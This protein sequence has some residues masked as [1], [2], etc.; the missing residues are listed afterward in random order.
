MTSRRDPRQTHVRPR[1]PSNGRP[2]PAKIHTRGPSSTR[3][4]V[5]RPIE[6]N[7]GLPLVGKLGLIMAIALLGVAVLYVGSGGLGKVFGG[8]SSA[9][10]GFVTSVTSTPTPEPSLA[11][12]A[13]APTLQEP[14]EPY[15]Q[16]STVDLVVTVPPGVIG[17]A[18]QRIRVYL[19]LK[20]QSAVPIQEAPLAATAQTIIPVELTKGINDFSVTIVGPGGESQPSAVVRYVLDQAPA[21]ITITSPKEGAVVNGETVEIVGKT[22]ARSTLIAHNAA[23]GA[24]ITG[25]AATDGTFTLSL[26]LGTGI[27][28]ITITGTDPAGNAKEMVLTVRRGNGKLTATLGASAYRISVDKLPIDMTLQVA[29]SDPDGNA[30]VGAAVTFTLSIPGIPTITG[31]GVTDADGRAT[32]TTSIPA[33]ADPGQG[34]ATV[35]VSSDQFGSTQDQ[36][37]ITIQPAPSPS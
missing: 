15:T 26:A 8:I 34:L 27:N 21:K 16:E 31:D 22:Q 32:F 11:A 6:R 14:A 19:A 10:S 36:S 13:D 1:P 29:V 18:T 33:G 4:A 2:A 30:L 12:V 35:L 3:L 20:D 9:L 25:N 37:V 17:D 28:E 24:S 5:H 23:N 7:R